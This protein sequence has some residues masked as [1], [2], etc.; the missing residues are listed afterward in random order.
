MAH[1]GRV[2]WLSQRRRSA[3]SRKLDAGRPIDGGCTLTYVSTYNGYR[4]MPGVQ[5]PTPSPQPVERPPRP[6]LLLATIRELF[7]AGQVQWAIHSEWERMPEREIDFFDVEE[8]IMK[9]YTP[10][11]VF[12]GRKPKEWG[13]KVVDTL[14]GTKRKVGIVCV[15]RSG[16]LL[17]IVTTEWE[18]K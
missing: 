13:L 15:V 1:V 6:E 8:V 3:P 7:Q 2:A 9:G 5:P 17:I 16:R 12:R 10:E 4:Y 18:D 14:P 11:P